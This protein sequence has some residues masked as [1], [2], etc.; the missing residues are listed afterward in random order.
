MSEQTKQPKRGSL[1]W[2]KILGSIFFF[3][4]LFITIF[5]SMCPKYVPVIEVPLYLLT[6][7]GFIYWIWTSTTGRGVLLRVVLATVL[8]M[9][10]VMITSGFVHSSTFPFEW[11]DEGTQKRILERQQK[12]LDE[13]GIE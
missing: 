13:Q 6:I 12:M 11:F 8:G 2:V 1:V 5:S 7:I 10:I 4:L 3:L 9:A